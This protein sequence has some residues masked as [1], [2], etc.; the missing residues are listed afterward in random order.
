[1]GRAGLQLTSGTLIYFFN[2][3]AES[4]RGIFDLTEERVHQGSSSSLLSGKASKRVALFVICV[5]SIM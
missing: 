5:G 2:F 3:P 4:W 1:M